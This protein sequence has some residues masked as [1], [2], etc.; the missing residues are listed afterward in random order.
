MHEEISQQ[1]RAVKLLLQ[2]P[3]QM[4]TAL[5]DNHCASTAGPTMSSALIE[6][7][8]DE[9]ITKGIAPI[10]REYWKSV[11]PRQEVEAVGSSVAQDSAGPIKRQSKKQA[12]QV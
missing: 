5:G 3:D 4:S 9:L 11:A 1:L 10:K 12:K 8:T 7:S 2:L 6:L